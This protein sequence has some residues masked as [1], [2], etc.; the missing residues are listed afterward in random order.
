MLLSDEL[1]ERTWPHPRRQWFGPA[2]IRSTDIVEQVNGAISLR[3]Y[4]IDYSSSDSITVDKCYATGL[5]VAP[6]VCSNPAP[7]GL[8][9]SVSRKDQLHVSD[10]NVRNRPI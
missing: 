4:G 10:R 3:G 5:P 8:N 2:A 1:V 7:N 6:A 9:G